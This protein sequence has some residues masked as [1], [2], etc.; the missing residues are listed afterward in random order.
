[1]NVY[2]YGA[3]GGQGTSTVAAMIAL[4]YARGG[5]SVQLIGGGDLYAILGRELGGTA[6]DGP[7]TLGRPGHAPV[8]VTDGG[9]TP[10][11]AVRPDETYMVLRGPCYL[12][13][14]RALAGGYRPD[15]VIL[16]REPGRSLGADDVRDVLGLRVVAEIELTPATARLVD[17]GMLERHRPRQSF[18]LPA[19]STGLVP[20][21]GRRSRGID[22]TPRHPVTHECSDC[23]EWAQLPR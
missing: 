10:P 3:K 7:I 8:T 20:A 21:P 5:C 15:G 16:V 23:Q 13:L 2:V 11:P 1:M 14:R 22:C 4:D 12:A 17:A 6:G 18:Y 9:T 19:I